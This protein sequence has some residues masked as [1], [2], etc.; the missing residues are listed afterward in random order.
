MRSPLQHR[1]ARRSRRR[2]NPGT[3]VL[4]AAVGFVAL[5]GGGASAETCRFAGTTDYAGRVAATTDVTRS[6]DTTRVDV[7]VTFESTTMFW[8]GVRYLLEE[9]STWRTGQLESVAVN[10]RYLV[11][12]HIVR[13]QWDDF[14][15]GA[16]GLQ[17]QRV[18]AKTLA[19]FR[20]RH[21]GFVRHWDPAT[22]AQP[23]LHDY[24]SASPERRSDLDLRASPL[25]AGLRS[26]LALAFYWVRW[27]RPGSQHAA[28][29]LPGFKHD[30]LVELS[31]SSAPTGSG[32]L[33][34]APL[35]YPALSDS[36]ESTATALVSPDGHL[37]Q[38]AF[39]LFTPHGWGR[40]TI[41]QR[42]CEGVA[43]VPARPG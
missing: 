34:R 43:V 13:Q 35:H 21:P 40:G 31:A 14:Q 20:V 39:A 25:P 37:L 6:G 8:L 22:F 2:P 4:L 9:V 27:L 15:R 10:S 7:A 29:F 33:W 1:Q 11:G 16:D 32:T 30:R 41:T 26:P 19:D 28:V 36:P 38:I 23:W 24:P 42:G 5:S 3:G 17:A 12:D 18:Q